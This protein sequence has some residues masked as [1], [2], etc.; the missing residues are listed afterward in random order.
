MNNGIDEL[1]QRARQTEP[2]LPAEDFL[3]VL[4]QS[5]SQN[6]NSNQNSN[7][8]SNQLKQPRYE[9]AL[10]LAAAIATLLVF[11]LT[12]ISFWIAAIP[13]QAFS[14]STLLAVSTATLVA[15]LAC[16]AFLEWGDV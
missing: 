1:F 4:K 5:L 16:F 11:T 14:A 6:Q 8:I 13:Y 12:P 2:E 3:P 10:V 9:W 7:Q 15:V